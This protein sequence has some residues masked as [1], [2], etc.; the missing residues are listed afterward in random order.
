MTLRAAHR[1]AL[2]GRVKLLVSA[3]VVC[4]AGT[5]ILNVHF[6]HARGFGCLRDRVSAADGKERLTDL[7]ATISVLLGLVT[8][9]VTLVFAQTFDFV[10]LLLNVFLLILV[11]LL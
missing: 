5:A 6:L 8:I 7:S 4:G 1:F 3:D 2:I 11:L 9:V 10:A